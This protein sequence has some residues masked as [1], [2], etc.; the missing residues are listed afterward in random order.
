MYKAHEVEQDWI[1][2]FGVGQERAGHYVKIH[3]TYRNA[4]DEMFRRYGRE[5]AF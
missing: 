4:R 5:W 3:G 2:T 1:F